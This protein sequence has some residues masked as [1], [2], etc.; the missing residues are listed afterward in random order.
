[1]LQEN[2]KNTLANYTVTPIQLLHQIQPL[3]E[4]CFKGNFEVKNNSIDM[5]FENGQTFILKIGEVV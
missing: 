3:L 1:M 2:K 4:E 5:R